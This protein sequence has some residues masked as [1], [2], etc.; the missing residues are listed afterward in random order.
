MW[1]F[2]FEDFDFLGRYHFPK[3]RFENIR[4]MCCT[5]TC[6]KKFNKG[7]K[8]SNLG[9][10]FQKTIL[11]YKKWSFQTIE[12]SQKNLKIIPSQKLLPR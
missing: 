6:F 3:P 2:S 12:M 1:F 8:K 10:F 5:N 9:K 7:F 4:N 11:G